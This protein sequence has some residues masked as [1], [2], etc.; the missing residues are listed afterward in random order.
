MIIVIII[1][2]IIITV[3]III[4]IAWDSQEDWM[5]SKIAEHHRFLPSW[6]HTQH[7]K[8]QR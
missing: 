5:S 2:I 6:K 8:L 3:I 7:S 1:I 4:N